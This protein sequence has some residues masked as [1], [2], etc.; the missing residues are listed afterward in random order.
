MNQ[1]GAA[2]DP[3]PEFLNR[4]TDLK[5]SI[6]KNSA[7]VLNDLWNPT[8]PAG[9]EPGITITLKKIK[10]ISDQRVELDVSVYGATGFPFGYVVTNHYRCLMKWI[11]GWKVVERGS[12]LGFVERHLV[13]CQIV[14]I[15]RLVYLC[16]HGP[17]DTSP[18]SSVPTRIRKG[19]IETRDTEG[20]KVKCAFSPLLRSAPSPP[21]A[22]EGCQDSR[23]GPIFPSRSEGRSS[24]GDGRRRTSRT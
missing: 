14:V 1:H 8:D 20:V 13:K 3:T 10:W 9:G 24:S 21:R 11:G 22:A 6:Q 15:A 18:G 7:A 2:I 17:K 19:S 12:G 16:P 4:F 5:A 23:R